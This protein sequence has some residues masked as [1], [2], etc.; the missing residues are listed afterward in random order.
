MLTQHPVFKELSF[1]KGIT[2]ASLNICSIT[3]KFDDIKLLLVQS[4]LDL[5]FL[6]ETWL[7]NSI[8]DLELHV[9]G[10]TL[11]RF[12]RDAGSGKKGGGGLLAFARNHYHFEPLTNWNVCTPDIEA[13]WLKLSL[14]QTRPTFL[15]N[16]YRPPDGN[17]NFAINILENKIHDIYSEAP[18]DIVL[19]E[20]F[21]VDL[22]D[23]RSH[24]T[25]KLNTFL[26][27]CN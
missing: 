9:P 12:D 3:R 23:K 14:P 15:V 27:S 16:V 11:H 5:L 22:L 17:L 7:N 10:Y 13:Q 6:N 8:G 26:K 20:D 18:G 25:R 2:Y 4:K 24:K 1:L 19:M 21:N